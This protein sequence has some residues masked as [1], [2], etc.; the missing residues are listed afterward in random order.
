MAV[1]KGFPPCLMTLEC[2]VHHAYSMP[3]FTPTARGAMPNLGRF[4]VLM[5]MVSHDG[6]DDDADILM[7]LC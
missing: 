2:V 5:L 6:H 4:E 3:S 7:L 1:D